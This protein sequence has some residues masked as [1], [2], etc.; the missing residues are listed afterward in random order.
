MVPLARPFVGQCLR[1][2][3]AIHHALNVSKPLMGLYVVAAVKMF[4]L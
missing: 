2:C 1:L 4:S 3:G